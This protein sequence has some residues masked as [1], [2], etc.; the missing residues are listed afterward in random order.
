MSTMKTYT[1]KNE[2][3]RVFDDLGIAFKYL[4]N[5]LI[6]GFIFSLYK[7]S[8]FWES[9]RQIIIGGIVAGY[10]TPVIVTRTEMNMNYVGF[11]SFVIGMTGM[12]IIDSIY[13][14]VA[15]RV[16]KF[17]EATIEYVKKI[18]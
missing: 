7:R 15:S 11:T 2:F 13:K 1:M 14:Y 10:F 4:L 18:F 3:L 16:R 12:V 5:G 8:K 9:V 6:G 17:R